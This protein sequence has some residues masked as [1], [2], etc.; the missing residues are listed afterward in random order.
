MWQ[1]AIDCDETNQNIYF[2]THINVME[3]FFD[4]LC[5]EEKVVKPPVV[6]FKRSTFHPSRGTSA[7]Q[8]HTE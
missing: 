1:T 6:S 8:W 3:F 2:F 7:Q 5:D 4:M